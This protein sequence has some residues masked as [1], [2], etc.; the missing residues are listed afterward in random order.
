[1]IPMWLTYRRDDVESGHMIEESTAES[2]GFLF[3]FP[4]VS[5]ILDLGLL[6]SNMVGFG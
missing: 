5:V 4:P 1:M 3:G 2:S 6:T